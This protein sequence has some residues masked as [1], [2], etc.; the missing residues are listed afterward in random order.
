[1]DRELSRNAARSSIGP[2]LII[3]A[4]NSDRDPKELAEIMASLEEDDRAGA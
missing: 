3:Y 1:M 2:P 4:E